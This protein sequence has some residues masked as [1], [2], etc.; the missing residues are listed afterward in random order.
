MHHKMNPTRLLRN[1]NTAHDEI[2]SAL[3]YL[4]RIVLATDP[5]AARVGLHD[6][7]AQFEQICAQTLSL[8]RRIRIW[9]TTFP[10]L[11]DAVQADTEAFLT[12][13]FGFEAEAEDGEDADDEHADFDG[14]ADE[15]D[16]DEFVDDDTAA[17][18]DA[19]DHAA[20]SAKAIDQSGFALSDD[21][22][23]RLFGIS[24]ASATAGVRET[25][26]VDIFGAWQEGRRP[27]PYKGPST[28]KADEGPDYNTPGEAV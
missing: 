18:Q 10:E 19:Q 3:S 16:E 25:G 20:T 14:E 17:L 12:D 7:Q 2:T 26:Y 23:G 11:T 21:D 1:L 15:D 22:L 6:M 27:G 4:G 13:F 9:A 28:P 8:K 24:A 5:G